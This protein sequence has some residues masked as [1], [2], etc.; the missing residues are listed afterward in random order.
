MAYDEGLA[1]RIREYLEGELG[2][3]EKQMFG[4]LGF[5]IDGNTCCA[6]L[7]DD[8][9]A[10]VGPDAYAAALG[11]PHAASFGMPGRKP[12]TG[13]V[14]VAAAGLEEDAAVAEWV[15]RGVAFARSLP[16]K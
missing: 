6:V 10:R 11:R 7:G 13:W 14:H 8:L 4:G 9:L 15:G 1:G 5:L 3:R 16:P 2:L 12:M